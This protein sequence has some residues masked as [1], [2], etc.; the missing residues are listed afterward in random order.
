RS[1]QFDVISS[2]HNY[3]RALHLFLE[4]YNLET[5]KVWNTLNDCEDLVLQF[6]NFM[7]R[8]QNQKKSE[9]KQKEQLLLNEG[10]RKNLQKTR[11]FVI[12]G[13]KNIENYIV[14]TKYIEDSIEFSIGKYTELLEEGVVKQNSFHIRRV[15]RTLKDRTEH[16]KI[17]SESFT[18]RGE[19]LMSR[20]EL[21]DSEIAFETQQK[22]EKVAYIIGI[23]G[24]LIAFLTMFQDLILSI[25]T[26]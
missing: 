25:F 24:I 17:I 3:N 11:L 12:N 1:E 22:I 14:L 9:K 13:I 15:L 7:S 20:L 2:Y 5:E 8:D 16:L 21:Y 26:K 4:K 6:E 18:S 10:T 23:L 19:N